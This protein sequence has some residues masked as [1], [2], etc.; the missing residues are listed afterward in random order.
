MSWCPLPQA[1]PSP[2]R[3]LTGASLRTDSLLYPFSIYLPSNVTQE[4]IAKILTALKE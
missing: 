1:A 3:E 4:E 2:R